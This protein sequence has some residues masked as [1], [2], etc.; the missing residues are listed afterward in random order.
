MSSPKSSIVLATGRQLPE[1]SAG[2]YREPVDDLAEL[3]ELA[4]AAAAL[5]AWEESVGGR[6]VALPG[7][8]RPRGL[9]TSAGPQAA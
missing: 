3:R 9:E 2:W 1:L 6:H 5:V 4:A 8:R 7:S